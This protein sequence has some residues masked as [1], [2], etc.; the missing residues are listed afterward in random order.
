MAVEQ[1]SSIFVSLVRCLKEMLFR[2]KVN[3]KSAL[4]GFV[5]GRKL[6]VSKMHGTD[7]REKLTVALSLNCPLHFAEPEY[8]LL[9]LRPFTVSYPEPAECSLHHYNVFM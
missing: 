1:S 8:P 4:A 6:T 3:F 5:L 7:L 9:H 2:A